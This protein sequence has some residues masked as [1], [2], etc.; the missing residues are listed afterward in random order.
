MGR[1]ISQC[2]GEMRGFEERARYMIEKSEQALEK[3]ISKQKYE[4]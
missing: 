3:V 4:P 1:R 2:S